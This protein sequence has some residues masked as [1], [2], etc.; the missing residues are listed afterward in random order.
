MVEKMQYDYQMTFP[1]LDQYATEM[2]Y[3]AAPDL[4]LN[5]DKTVDKLGDVSV[6]LLSTYS[7]NGWDTVS[8]CSV[9]DLNQS[10]A[11]QK[12][13]PLFME[14]TTTDEEDGDVS[15]TADF[16]PWTISAN[17]DG[18]S[19][20]LKIPIKSGTLTYNGKK[21]DMK[22]SRAVIQ[23][24]LSYYPL[25]KGSVAEPNYYNLD[26]D[27]EKSVDS[28]I[29]VVEFNTHLGF[30]KSSIAQSVFSD[31]LNLDSTLEKIGVLFATA[32]LNMADSE[33]FKWLTPTYASYAYIDVGGDLSKSKFAVL[34]MVMNRK[35]P[36]V[37]QAPPVVYSEGCN[38]AFMINREVYVEYQLLP[39]LPYAFEGAKPSDFSLGS[40]ENGESRCSI[41]AKN[42]KLEKVKYGGLDYQ[43]VMDDMTLEVNE[44]KIVCAIRF[45]TEISPGIT[46]H[47]F[48]QTENGIK[49]GKNKAK[50]IIM[51]YVPLRKPITTH[52]TDVSAGVIVTEVL[53]E[54]IVAVI[55]LG[56]GKVVATVIQKVICAVIVALTFAVI[57]VIIHVI[58]EKVYSEGVQEQ[59]PSIMPMTTTA[60]KYVKW[61]FL[62]EAHFVPKE[63]VL[64]GTLCFMGVLE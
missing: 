19:V 11:A 46:A 38:Y 16:D 64:N 4:F 13:Y 49:L 27:K 39:S 37:H 35:P 2:A 50:E 59:M 22:D 63:A 12:T 24:R 26:I 40:G 41:K 58:I 23:V 54:I 28:V 20:N 33:D 42:L 62:K 34:C 3:Q 61:P 29:S 8:V 57:S 47:T 7:T 17:G 53:S 10:V 55:G 48:V 1:M 43:P 9:T 60:T 56:I 6:K 5:Q 15:L 44:D 30:I 14:H 52:Q 51:E 21:F 45:T 31:W 32:Q 18:G 36:E 25:I